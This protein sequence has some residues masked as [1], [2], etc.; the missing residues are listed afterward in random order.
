M[1][2]GLAAAGLGSRTG[3][4]GDASHITSLSQGLTLMVHLGIIGRRAGMSRR[5]IRT[6]DSL[7]STACGSRTTAHGLR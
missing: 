2:G 7:R 3:E 1:L 6:A 5:R 4:K